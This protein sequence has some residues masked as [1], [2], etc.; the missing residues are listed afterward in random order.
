MEEMHQLIEH[1]NNVQ[2]SHHQ[3]IGYNSS[4]RSQT[5][6]QIILRDSN[7]KIQGKLLLVDLSSCQRSEANISKIRRLEGVDVGKSLLALKECVRAFDMRNQCSE[8]K[9]YLPFR[10]CKLTLA[11]KDSFIAKNNKTRI[12]M[13]ACLHPGSSSAE[14]SLNAL[15]YCSRLKIIPKS[16][17]ANISS[18]EA[19]FEPEKQEI[20]V[21]KPFETKL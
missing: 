19:Q 9:R 11:L 8:G 2:A 3:T 13:I 7:E 6:C 20:S 16:N 18:E 1:A 10:G 5:I 4:S 21:E 14:H 12:V 15:R 17:P